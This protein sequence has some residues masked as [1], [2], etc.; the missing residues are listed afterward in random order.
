MPTK[1]EFSDLN[2]SLAVKKNDLKNSAS[3]T[4]ALEREREQRLEDLLKVEQ[5]E[6][7]LNVELVNL[8]GKI[9]GMK[10]SLG[11]IGNLDESKAAAE[12]TIQVFIKMGLTSGKNEAL[13]VISSSK[14]SFGF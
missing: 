5:L 12:A 8:Q 9:D 13:R 7:K 11:L 3:T 1:Q 10:S 14:G 6:V 2:T 4:E